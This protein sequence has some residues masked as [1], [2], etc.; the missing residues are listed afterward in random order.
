[1]S[2]LPE[3]LRKHTQEF[4][5][6]IEALFGNH[7]VSLIVYGSATTEE[8]VHKKS[9]VNVLVVLDEEGI[10]NLRPVHKKISGWRKNGLQPLFLTDTYIERSLD[11]FPIEFLNMK[12]AYHLLWGKDVLQS[13]EFDRRDLRL[14]CERELKGNLLHLRQRYILTR[15]NK[16]ELTALIKESAVAFTAIFKAMLFLKNIELPT[17]KSEAVLQTCNEFGMDESLFSKLISIRKGEEKPDQPELERVV[18]SYIREIA[19]LS[20]VVDAMELQ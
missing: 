17:V 3:S 9:D 16:N 2:S 6:D 5:T 18:A 13:L 7:V 4:Q 10:Q 19:A 12:S 8:Y 15:G 14:Q 20:R 1:M 11:S